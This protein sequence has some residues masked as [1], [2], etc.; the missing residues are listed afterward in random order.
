[1][2]K[3]MEQIKQLQSMLR[4]CIFGLI[5]GCGSHK[6]QNVSYYVGS[7]STIVLVIDA[8]L[9]LQCVLFVK[10]GRTLNVVHT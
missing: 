10:I 9:L 8:G 7:C 1:M 4:H 2:G 6:T 5:Y 3:H